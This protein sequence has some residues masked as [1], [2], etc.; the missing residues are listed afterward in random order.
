MIP[1]LAAAVA[2]LAGCEDSTPASLDPETVPV[3][4][5]EVILPWEEFGGAVEVYDGFGFTAELFGSVLAEDYQ[6]VLDARVLTSF[7]TLPWRA[8]VRDAGGT[9]RTDSAMTF[10]GGRIVTR[11]DTLSGVPEGPVTVSFGTIPREWD[12]RTVAWEVAVDTLN[13]FAEWA[14]PGAGPVQPLGEAVWDPEESDSL[15]LELDSATLALLGDTLEMGPGV[16]L[17]MLTPGARASVVDADLRIYT[18]PNVNPDTV[19]TLNSPPR[20]LTF[21]YDPVPQPSGDRLRIGGAPSWRTV[22]RFALPRTLD[23][24]ADFCARVGCPFELTASSLNAATLILTTAASEPAFQPTDTLF[25]DART[26]LAP[27]ILPK[28]PLSS[29]LVGGLGI[30][31]PPEAFAA[32]AGTEVALPVTPFIRGLL[33]DAE[34]VVLYPDLALLTPIE[35]LGI[36]FGTFDGPGAPGAPRLRLILT[37]ADTVVLP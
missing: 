35:P 2:G 13:D 1:V 12:P 18:R 32:S 22:L 27:L 25:V 7:T 30:S 14:E 31:M 11:F 19:V 24:P 4:T 8:S 26:V 3:R 36:G 28:S 29:S 17:R 16:R 10:V 34:G 6:G 23:G 21:V 15:V 37:V 9:T 20:R 33:I 5:V